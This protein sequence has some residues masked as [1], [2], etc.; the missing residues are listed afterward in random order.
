M[1]K[2]VRTRKV[3]QKTDQGAKTQAVLMSLLRAAELQGQ[4]PIE[5]VVCLAKSIIG[6]DVATEDAFKMAT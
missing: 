5:V 6:D 3:F 4:N 2:P 1:G